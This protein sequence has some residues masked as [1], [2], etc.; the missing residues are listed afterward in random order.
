MVRPSAAVSTTPLPSENPFWATTPVCADIWLIALMVVAM[1]EVMLLVLLAES[2]MST[3]LI[4]KM[5]CG[6]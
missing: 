3:P 4:V 1:L 6:A 2:P 5:P